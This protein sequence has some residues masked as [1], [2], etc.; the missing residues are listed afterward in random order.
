M[1][2]SRWISAA[3]L[4]ASLA[5]LAMVALVPGRSASAQNVAQPP[6]GRFQLVSPKENYAWRL[7]TATGAIVHCFNGPQGI[8]CRAP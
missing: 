1:S 4:I 6:I 5:T 2:S 7:D 3:A 8:V